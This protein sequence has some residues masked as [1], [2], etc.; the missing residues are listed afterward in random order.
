M[1]GGY[2]IDSSP[3]THVTRY[4][5]TTPD[6]TAKG[7]DQYPELFFIEEERTGGALPAPSGV[8]TV[9]SLH[10]LFVKISRMEGGADLL[11][12]HG[13][14]LIKHDF[15]YGNKKEEK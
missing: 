9:E 6:E 12:A 7:S 13:V 8:S 3:Y 10:S 1:F 11:A 4:H 5:A 14:F 15:W 2:L